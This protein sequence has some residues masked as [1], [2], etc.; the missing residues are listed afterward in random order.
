MSAAFTE[1]AEAIRANPELK[2]KIA[3]AGSIQERQQILTDAGISLPTQADMQAHHDNSL[4]AAVGG[5]GNTTLGVQAAS[6]GAQ[7]CV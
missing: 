2:D 6:A 3:A 4:A 1:V 5:E 7:A